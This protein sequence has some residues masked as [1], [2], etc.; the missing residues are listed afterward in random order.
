MRT[1]KCTYT[2]DIIGYGIA[3]W[4]GGD[5][6]PQDDGSTASGLSTK[7]NPTL[8]GCALPIPTC[9][10]T[11]GS[12]LPILPYLKTMVMITADNG[13]CVTVPLIDVGPALSTNHAID[14]TQQTFKDLGGDLS[15]GIL[16]VQYRILLAG[17]V[18]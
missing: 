17:M 10:A 4:F 2:G 18:L 13:K 3:T 8:Q 7:G 11:K 9:D 16:S 1:W 6:D 5:D 12:P 14:V 15:G